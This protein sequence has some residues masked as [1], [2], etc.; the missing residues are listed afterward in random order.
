MP[1]KVIADS[2]PRGKETGVT[3]RGLKMPGYTG[4]T[5]QGLNQMHGKYSPS[6]VMMIK[7]EDRTFVQVDV[8]PKVGG[9]DQADES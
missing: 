2:R 4:V 9:S 8:V 6:G 3:K 5:N 1:V 7:R